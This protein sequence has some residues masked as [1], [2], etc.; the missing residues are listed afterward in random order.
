MDWSKQ[1]QDMFKSWTDAQTKTW[2]TWLDTVKSFDPS[3]PGQAWE[4][5]VDAWQQSVKNTL[6][7]QVEGSRIWAES[8]SSI[9][10]APKE[11]ANWAQQVQDMTQRWTDL[12]T[13]MWDNW[14]DVMKKA[15]I[16]KFNT[17][18]KEGS[19]M[20]GP[21]QDMS[22]KMMDAQAEWIRNFTA[23]AKADK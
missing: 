22:K 4:K 21:W 3:Q 17:F 19:G 15:D 1:T 7:A 11:T 23:Q 5:T 16:D 6:S 18:G 9:Q 10:G 12:Q 2:N 14:F 13:Q 20:M 8:V